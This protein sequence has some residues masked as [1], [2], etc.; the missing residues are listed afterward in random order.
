MK[1]RLYVAC[2]MV[3]VMVMVMLTSACRPDPDSPQTIGSPEAWWYLTIYPNPSRGPFM[4]NV[5][6]RKVPLDL[7]LTLRNSSG[8]TLDVRTYPPQ[9]SGDIIA[10]FDLTHQPVGLYVLTLEAPGLK[11]TRPVLLVK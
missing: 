7:T 6:F 2:C 3:M 8:K 5:Q 10:V 4:V 9:P 1:K 11:Q